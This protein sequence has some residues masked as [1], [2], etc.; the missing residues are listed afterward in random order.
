LF[1]EK[2]IDEPTRNMIVFLIAKL[3]L[4]PKLVYASQCLVYIGKGKRF[5]SLKRSL[6]VPTRNMVV[7]VLTPILVF[8][9]YLSCIHRKG[10]RS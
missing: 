3:V 9:S 5:C 1:V 10:Q 4:T 8:P 2:F 7:L 6:D